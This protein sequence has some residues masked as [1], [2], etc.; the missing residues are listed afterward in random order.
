[1][2]RM[3]I[4]EYDYKSYATLEFSLLFFALHYEAGLQL[5]ISKV[6]NIEN[7]LSDAVLAFTLG[8]EIK[9][10]ELL[11]EILD[12][13]PSCFDAWRA[14]AEVHLALNE[15][16]DAQQACL[17]ALELEPEDLA[18][19]VSLARILVRKGDKDGAEEATAR[20]RILGWK[21]E[22]AEGS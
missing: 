17:M 3:S 7:K 16:D 5:M 4:P 8:E 6:M 2:H 19:V 14:L 12:E 15:T 13:K 11:L 20:A 22:L 10:R 9:A 21:E 18:S 1:M